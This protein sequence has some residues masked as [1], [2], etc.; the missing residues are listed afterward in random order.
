MSLPVV[1]ILSWEQVHFDA[2]QGNFVSINSFFSHCKE[3]RHVAFLCQKEKLF[4]LIEKEHKFI[5]AQISKFDDEELVDNKDV[6][7]EEHKLEDEVISLSYFMQE[8]DCDMIPLV[9]NIDH[10]VPSKLI[11]IEKLIDI[12]EITI[13]NSSLVEKDNF[14]E[15]PY[16]FDHEK[17]MICYRLKLGRVWCFLT[18]I[19][20]K[21]C[22]LV[23]M[24][25]ILMWI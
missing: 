14:Y 6:I 21:T 8:E 23:F 7:F 15:F 20:R 17:S 13:L 2:K 25:V 16:V 4:T 10:E 11:V 9:E 18:L 1:E 22:V 19:W 12:D 5:E 3:F 24:L